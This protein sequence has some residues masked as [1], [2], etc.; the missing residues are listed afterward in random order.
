M[1]FT[2]SKGT[3]D[4]GITYKSK[5]S[6]DSSENIATGYSDAS[7]ANNDDHSSVSGYTFLASEGTITWGSKKQNV[8]S[9]S[10]TEAEYICLSD[11]MRVVM[12]LETGS[13]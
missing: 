1:N 6:K 11:A 13:F 3:K 4:L 2:I 5:R 10:T 12:L 9:L 8:I 7:F